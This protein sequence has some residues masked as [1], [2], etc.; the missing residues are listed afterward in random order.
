MFDAILK[1]FG[2]ILSFFSDITGGFYLFGLFIFAVLVKL[3]L[4]PFAVKQQKTSIKQAKMRPKEM[5]I[6]KKYKG[7]N[8]Q[9]TQQKMQ[10][11]VMDLY[12][13]EGYNPMGGC[14]PVL[15][16]MPVILI[17]YNVIINPLKYICGWSK[18]QISTIAT[19][20]GLEKASEFA[21]RDIELIQHLNAANESV[22]NAALEAAELGTVN[23]ADMPNFAMGAFDL[24]KTPWFTS[25]LI[26]V[27]IL[28]FVF[29]FFA[30]KITRKFTY[31][32]MAGD[33][34][35]NST[36]KVMDIILPAM[37]T[38]IAFTVPA[39]IGIYWMFNNI[40]GVVQTIIINKAMPLPTCTEEDIKAAEKE[41]AGKAYKASHPL[42]SDTPSAKKSLHY[43]DFDDEEEIADL[44]EY[45][46]VYDKTPEEKA[47]AEEPKEEI[48]EK[49][50][51]L[52]GKA[53]M[54][55]DEP[56]KGNKE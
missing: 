51:K 25:I 53:E 13:R 45:E 1:F 41:I 7:R 14:L 39:A 46:S 27:P 52:F 54:K 20:I 16:Q 30:S 10:N 55:K 8:D 18:A 44:G 9:K 19:S 3:I 2:M 36:M 49:Q 32:P 15:I 11:E 35:T 21:N 22:A 56:K 43:I 26:L 50:K 47:N 23:F 37:T 24:S 6:R 48:S 40:L 42:P 33:Q 31:Q 5:A 17:L 4:V 28:T 12:Q 38:W 34:Q 29:Q